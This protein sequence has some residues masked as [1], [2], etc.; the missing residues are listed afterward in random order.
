MLVPKSEKSDLHGKTALVTG[1]AR[2]IG[3]ASAKALV[4]EGADVVLSDLLPLR[5]SVQQVSSIG[6]EALPVQCDVSNEEEV[7][8]LVK[9]AI[10]E[11]K[12]LDILVHCAGV[13]STT[14]LENITLQEWQDII[15]I[16]LTGTFLLCREVFP[17]MKEQEYGKIICIGSIAGKTGGLVTGP[18]YVAAKGGIH[19]MVK[20][21]ALAGAPYGIY[22]N[23][24]APGP[25]SSE[26]TRDFK[27]N[28]KGFPLS[29]MGEPEDIAEAV[30]YLSSQSSNWVT[31]QI[32][33]VNGGIR[34]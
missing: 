6:Q 16:N 19:S 13:A 31:G 1:A 20:V 23:G 8:N 33:D 30:V 28:P 5:E 17:H 32:L 34:M 21:L 26:M 7:A 4:R 29:R 24:I 27:Y 18:H 25:V 12:H 22:V 3:L 10:K 2:G 9:I 11:F 15:S 14:P